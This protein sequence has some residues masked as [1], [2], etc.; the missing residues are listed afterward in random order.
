M[1]ENWQSVADALRASRLAMGL[2]QE[3]LA[4][5]A[6]TSRSTIQNLE[7]GH[8]RK[9]I[10]RKMQEIATILGWPDAHIEQL[11]A[12]AASGPPAKEPPSAKPE[13][14][15]PHAD[16][17]FAVAHELGIG[18]LVDSKVIELGDSDAR[19]IVVVRAAEGATPEQLSQALEEWKRMQLQMINNEEVGG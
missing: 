9:R 14:S 16:L 18:D 17:P 1:Q 13:A 15:A 12:G 7:S 11:L 3:E 19:I 2:S 6:G 5:R 8:P 10:S 4:E